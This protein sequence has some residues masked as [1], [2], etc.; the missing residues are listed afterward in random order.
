MNS[1]LIDM[2]NANK[3]KDNQNGWRNCARGY[4]RL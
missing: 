4:P 2:A 3:N 1:K